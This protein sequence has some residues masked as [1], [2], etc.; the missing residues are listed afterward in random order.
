VNL[1]LHS[2]F[3]ILAFLLALAWFTPDLG[4]HWFRP[5]ERWGGRFAQRK[6]AVL[7]SIALATIFLR[8]TLL[9]A[10]PVPVPRVHDEFS[11]LLAADTFV[12]GRLANPPHPMWLFLET[13]HVL[14][15]PTY[16]SMYPP[17]QGAVLAIGQLMGNPWIGVLLS[18]A[19]MCAAMTWALQGWLP[20]QWAFL[21]GVLVLLRIGL[22]S[23]WINSYWGGAVAAIGGALVIGA[24]PRIKQRQRGTDSLLMG[25][26]AG[27]LANSRPL[28]GF[29]FCIPVLVALVT[30]L[31]SKRGAGLA[32][33]GIRV[34]MPVAAILTLTLA[35][36][37]HY[38]WRVTGNALLFPEA[39]DQ[40]VYTNFP[41]FLW[42]TPKPPLQYH[43]PQFEEFYIRVDS[44]V[45][46][47][48]LMVS[49][50]RKSH[51]VWLFFLGTSLSIPLLALPR[52]ITDKRIRFLVIQCACCAIGLL[53]VVWFYPHYA[54][55]LTATIF[56]IVI[57]AW[58][59]MRLWTC[60]GRALG[61]YLSRLIVLLLLARVPFSIA[62]H[63]EYP[64]PAWNIRRLRVIQQLDAM[65]GRHLVIV[66]YSEHHVVDQEWVY[67]G[68]NVDQ[69]KVV[70]ARE[71]QGQDL[72]PLLR[73]FQ[74]RTV[75]MVSADSS[76]SQLRLYSK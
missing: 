25:V 40:E 6:N 21:G 76:S 9:L 39:L 59:H 2:H 62:Y 42:Q 41:I 50:L 33:T 17:A 15:H 49:V 34:L 31:A 63:H 52:I 22:T 29:V 69:A 23:D 65:P 64:G 53:A 61:V 26:G 47:R 55:P 18:T 37:A 68:A 57:Q 8:V 28:E 4:D 3:F 45:Y 56:I 71:I 5:L 67:N 60:K 24:L 13:F 74:D 75:W 72:G 54:A 10:W 1:L 12:H 66:H 27:I 43:N 36:I 48:S 20:S 7:L 14:Q 11:N 44:N 16:A 19:G 70:W 73:Y 30:W 58:R 51:S 38:N 32:S 35:F 46:P